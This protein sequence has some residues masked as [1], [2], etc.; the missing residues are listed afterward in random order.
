[1]SRNPRSWCLGVFLT[2][3]SAA[4][5]SGTTFTVHVGAGGGFTF[6]P[7][8]QTIFVGDTVHWVWDSGLHSTTSGTCSDQ[9]TCTPDGS[10]TS[11]NLFSPATF[12]HTFSSPGT[13]PYYCA[14][15]L[16]MMTGTI[17]VKT[18][19]Q[20]HTVTPCRVADTRG[21]VG[22]HGGPS[23]AAGASRTLLITGQCGVP[24]TASAVSFNFT[25]TQAT[26]DGDLRVIPADQALPLVSTLNWRAGQTRANDAVVALGSSGDILVHVDQA[27]GTVDLIIDVN[28]Y[29]E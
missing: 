12:D 10:W 13:F 21:A 9:F 8:I 15:H 22:P 1:M 23:L 2:T 18:P 17:V 16:G 19:A 27:G 6:T 28:G 24:A 11:G 29:F 4:A 14:V 3:A 20:F 25:V 5:L 7:A 26:A